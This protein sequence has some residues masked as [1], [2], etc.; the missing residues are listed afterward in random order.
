M[1]EPVVTGGSVK[2]GLI[3]LILIILYLVGAKG[4]ASMQDWGWFGPTKGEQVVQLKGEVKQ[5]VEEK[6]QTEV[7]AGIK[8]EVAKVDDEVVVKQAVKQATIIKSTT[9][10]IAK[11]D[12]IIKEVEKA[13]DIQPEVKSKLVA[14]AIIDALWEDYCQGDAGCLDPPKP[15]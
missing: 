14:A 13:P 2:L 6:K 12:K 5:L 15:I 3:A 1:S 10:V 11:Q 4:C 9:Q 8:E 7:V